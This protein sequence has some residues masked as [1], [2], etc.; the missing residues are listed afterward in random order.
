MGAPGPGASM[1]V[2]NNIEKECLYMYMH[3]NTEVATSVFK[4]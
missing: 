2:S 1:H 3:K 4:A